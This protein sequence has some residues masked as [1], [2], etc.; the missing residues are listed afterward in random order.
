MVK[1]K[2][3]GDGGKTL[4]LFGLSEVNIR[5]LKAGEPIKVDLTE[6]GLEGE[7]LIFYG[8][9]ERDMALMLK[10]YINEDTVIHDTS[11]H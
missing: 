7:M 4:L 2:L 10:P 5:R 9:S 3:T 6:M 8:E 1:A 11:G